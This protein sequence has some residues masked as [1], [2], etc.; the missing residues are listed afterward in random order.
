MKF[1]KVQ[2][3]KLG[4]VLNPEHYPDCL[5]FQ[6]CHGF[7]C[8]LACGP[9][10][11]SIEEKLALIIFDQPRLDKNHSLDSEIVHHITDLDKAIQQALFLCETLLIPVD[12]NL[13]DGQ[14][15]ISFEHWLMGFF[16]AHFLHEEDW[17][18]ADEERASEMLLPFIAAFNEIENEALDSIRTNY[19]LLQ[20]LIFTIPQALQ[21]LYL[22]YT[23]GEPKPD[24]D[25][26]C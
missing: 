22:F 19:T 18:I 7:L 21:D 1:S 11:L 23:L 15:D 5:N 13:T 25:T 16:E 4:A 10:E 24:D 8:A 9:S 20:N 3:E 17:Y 2:A 6:E 12:L 14:I 26:E